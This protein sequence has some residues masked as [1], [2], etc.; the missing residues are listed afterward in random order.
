M[1]QN[2]MRERRC[3]Q[4]D[5]SRPVGGWGHYKMVSEP[6]VS[7]LNLDGSCKWL[8]KQRFQSE[9]LSKGTKFE[10]QSIPECQKAPRE[11]LDYV[12]KLRR[13]NGLW[14]DNREKIPPQPWYWATKFKN[15]AVG[16]V[17][18]KADPSQPSDLEKGA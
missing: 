8:M 12:Q 14:N 9:L 2:G 10:P 3:L 7:T 18:E 17:Q 13:Y 16:S 5:V 15:W 1:L 11:H 4:S 6:M